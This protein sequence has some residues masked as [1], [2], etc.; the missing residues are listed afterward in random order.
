[1]I[2]LLTGRTSISKDG[3]ASKLELVWKLNVRAGFTSV[4]V[5]LDPSMRGIPPEYHAHTSTAVTY[6]PSISI[7]HPDYFLSENSGIVSFRVLALSAQ[8]IAGSLQR[9]TIPFE[10]RNPRSAPKRVEIA[11]VTESLTTRKYQLVGINVAHGVIDFV[12]QRGNSSFHFPT[13]AHL[14]QIPY[15]E[16][17]KDAA[18]FQSAS[19]TTVRS[20]TW[21]M[22]LKYW[23]SSEGE[24]YLI[25]QIR[26]ID[27]RRPSTIPMRI[28]ICPFELSTAVDVRQSFLRELEIHSRLGVAVK[29]ISPKTLASVIE[30]ASSIALYGEALGLDFEGTDSELSDGFLSLRLDSD[31]IN[32]LSKIYGEIL[33]SSVRWSD[34]KD[35]KALSFSSEESGIQIFNRVRMLQKRS[36][37]N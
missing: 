12:T 36:S 24:Q 17:S 16:F 11:V 8:N 19:N 21:P 2:T 1:M 9:K 13:E 6:P 23:H 26:K 15:W 7:T 37:A 22:E 31:R 34:Y 30:D 32:D 25:S 18:L 20:V 10:W 3:I 35:G 28:A 27:R 14:C 29:V 4:K 5:Y 33:R